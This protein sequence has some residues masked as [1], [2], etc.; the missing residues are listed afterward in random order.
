MTK[1]YTNFTRLMTSIAGLA[2][3]FL[4]SGNANIQAQTTEL[5]PRE[6][7]DPPIRKLSVPERA[8]ETMEPQGG[9]I[10]SFVILPSAELTTA[11]D[12]NI[13]ASN[14]NEV[15]DVIFQLTPKIRARSDLSAPV[16]L[17]FDAVG[18]VRRFADNNS[19]DTEGY[20]LS[21]DGSWEIPDLG[22]QSFI[23]WGV[24]NARDWLARGFPGDVNSGAEPTI[25]YNTLGYT[26]FQYKPGA[27]SIL[28]H[29]SARHLDFDD[30]AAVGG[31]TVNND[32]RDR[33]IYRESMRFGYEFT[34]GYEGYLRGTLNQRRYE[35]SPDDAGYVRDSE[36]YE[37]VGGMKIGVSPITNIDVFAGYLRQSFDDPR[38]PT[39]DGP[40]FGGQLNWSPRREWQIAGS[41]ARSVEES[42]QTNYPSYLNTTY[43]MTAYYQLMPAL[44]FESR[45][46]Y[47]EF[48]F[49]RPINAAANREDSVL[50]GQLGVRY[51]MSPNLYT[52]LS[53]TQIAYSSNAVNQDYDRSVIY[54]TIG[55]QY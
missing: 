39:I 8:S 27:F 54:L 2:V 29:V 5:T 23:K 42:D 52:N 11:Y 1:V 53:Y 30:V 37:A 51:Y 40:G 21:H 36:G 20:L 48:D 31:G 55:A 34:R 33:W 15:D 47:S 17:N 13:F 6:N 3:V 26:G 50:T 43:A 41:V 7:Y 46:S 16:Q 32:D 14:R 10:G 44:R 9:R 18:I 22:E 38:L 19:E 12:S 49:D 35:T 45:I 28:T 24:A 25:F 4:V